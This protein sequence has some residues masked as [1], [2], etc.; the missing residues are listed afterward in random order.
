[1]QE[2][3][4]AKRTKVDDWLTVGVSKTDIHPENAT[5]VSHAVRRNRASNGQL[6]ELLVSLMTQALAVKLF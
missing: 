1:M 3:K 4:A 5:N 2:E 6:G